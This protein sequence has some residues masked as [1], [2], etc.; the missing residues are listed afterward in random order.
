MMINDVQRGMAP[1]GGLEPPPGQSPDFTIRHS[2][3]QDYNIACQVLSYSLVG[4]CMLAR[5][6][7]RTFIKPRF[8]LEDCKSDIHH[9]RFKT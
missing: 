7:T 8:Q 5:V 4:I 3:V 6:Y 1:V 2:T 9:E